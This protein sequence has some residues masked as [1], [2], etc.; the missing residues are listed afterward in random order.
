MDLPVVGTAT[1]LAVAP[2]PVHVQ[3]CISLSFLLSA[4]TPSLQQPSYSSIAK[5]PRPGVPWSLLFCFVLFLYH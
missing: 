4:A 5:G 2:R 3:L 1:L